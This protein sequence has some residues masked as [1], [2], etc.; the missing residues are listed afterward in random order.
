MN[1]I[2]LSE[3]SVNRQGQ[4]SFLITTEM[5]IKEKR[6][7]GTYGSCMITDGETVVSLNIW[8]MT[9]KDADAGRAVKGGCYTAAVK[10]GLYQ[11]SF[12]YSTRLDNLQEL[13]DSEKEGLVVMPPKSIAEMWK[14][15]NEILSEF[16]GTNR[17]LTGNILEENREKFCTWAAAEKI[18]HNIYG[19]LLYH[20]YRMV[21]TAYNVQ[22]IANISISTQ[23]GKYIRKIMDNGL[24]HIVL[25]FLR[26]MP[27]F[28]SIAVAIGYSLSRIYSLDTDIVVSALMMRR[29]F[30]PMAYTGAYGNG[31]GMDR[32]VKSICK[33]DKIPETE[34][35]MLFRHCLYLSEDKCPNIPEGYAVLFAERMAEILEQNNAPIDGE[36]LVCAALLHDIGKLKELDSDSSG[37]VEY[38]VEGILFGH[39]AIGLH[40][41]EEIA[42]KSGITVDSRL[43]HCIA[44]HHGKTQWGALVPPQIPEAMLL[45]EIDNLDAKLYAAEEAVS[46]IEEGKFSARIFLL[47]GSR[48]YNR[49]NDQ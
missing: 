20:V 47:D 8:D 40:M 18:H 33:R 28:E 38:T 24:R 41:I 10:K 26:V 48:I 6:N 37:S 31:Y 16:T 22:A 49:C 23:T 19:G 27:P 36:L 29:A 44:S 3:I 1:K 2:K 45:H 46:G 43:L 14:R 34:K 4:V 21:L 39:H 32:E 35:I 7:G 11:D 12:T 15:I 30:V 42:D 17:V 25:E 5:E 9:Q 13:P